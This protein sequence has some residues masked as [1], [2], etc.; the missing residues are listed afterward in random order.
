MGV[1]ADAVESGLWVTEDV[2]AKD[3]PGQFH[4]VLS[5][6]GLQQKNSRALPVHVPSNSQP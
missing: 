1:A 3:L 4:F 6:Q 5:P 2:L